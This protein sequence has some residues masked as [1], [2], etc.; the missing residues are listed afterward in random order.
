MGDRDVLVR[1]GEVLDG[2]GAEA[3]AARVQASGPIT[4]RRIGLWPTSAARLMPVP[5]ALTRS[6]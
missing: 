3:V 4:A 2:T 1:G 5:V 6:R